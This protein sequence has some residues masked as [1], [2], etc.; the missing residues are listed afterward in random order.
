[1][2]Q[3]KGIKEWLDSSTAEDDYFFFARAQATLPPV[4]WH[5]R[6]KIAL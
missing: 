6:G 3:A 5:C 1:M 4:M 2:Q